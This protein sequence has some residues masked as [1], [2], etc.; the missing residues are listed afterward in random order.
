M[1]PKLKYWLEK[2]HEKIVAPE[3]KKEKQENEAEK[4]FLPLVA[5]LTG[6][7]KRH[8]CTSADA[9]LVFFVAFFVNCIAIALYYTALQRSTLKHLDFHSSQRHRHSVTIVALNWKKERERAGMLAKI[10]TVH[11][12]A[13]FVAKR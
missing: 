8:K 5:A 10:D 3:S 7:Q 9:I 6:G 1:L 4:V 11:I 2:I 13:I 12:Y